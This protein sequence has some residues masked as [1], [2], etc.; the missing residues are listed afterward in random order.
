VTELTSRFYQTIPHILSKTHK[1][2]LIDTEE[3]LEEKFEMLSRLADMII[4]K[5]KAIAASKP[6]GNLHNTCA[7]PCAFDMDQKYEGV[8]LRTLSAERMVRFRPR[9]ASLCSCVSR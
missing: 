3:K 5:E 6:A 4:V 1:P 9:M 8:L 2:P 7:L